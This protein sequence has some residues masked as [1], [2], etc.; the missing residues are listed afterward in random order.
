VQLEINRALYMDERRL[1]RLDTFGVVAQH[2]EVVSDRLNDVV[3]QEL[4]ASYRSAAE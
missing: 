1:E 2:L 4:H 3:M